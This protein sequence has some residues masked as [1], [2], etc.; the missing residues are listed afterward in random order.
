MF[1]EQEQLCDTE[2]KSEMSKDAIDSVP[3]GVSLKLLITWKKIL[4]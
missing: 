4:V 1:Q 2:E 3:A